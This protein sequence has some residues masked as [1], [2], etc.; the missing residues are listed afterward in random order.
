MIYILD[1]MTRFHKTVV[2]FVLRRLRRILGFPSFQQVQ[3]I[4]QH[5]LTVHLIVTESPRQR[6]GLVQRHRCRGLVLVDAEI[7]GQL[8][9]G[10][11]AAQAEQPRHKVDHI[12]CSPA[13]EAV[14]VILV[15][16][17]AGMPVIMEGA[18]DHVAP[19]DLA[20]VVLGGLLHGDN[21]FYCFKQIHRLCPPKNY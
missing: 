17:H 16:L 6:I 11:V 21:G 10:L 18:A 15:Q 19:V 13:A 4:A 14:E 3:I 5:P 8:L 12:P 2:Q 1:H 9:C 7:I 20:A